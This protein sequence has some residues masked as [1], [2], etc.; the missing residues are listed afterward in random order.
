MNVRH[1]YM[2]EISDIALERKKF[3]NEIVL[4]CFAYL[5]TYGCTVCLLSETAQQTSLMHPKRRVLG[6][7]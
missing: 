5:R 6:A 7:G 2:Y 1:T 3:A 4:F